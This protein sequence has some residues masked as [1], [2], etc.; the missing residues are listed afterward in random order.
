MPSRL[1]GILFCLVLA[2]VVNYGFNQWLDK[3]IPGWL[4]PVSSLDGSSLSSSL[5]YQELISGTLEASPTNAA[6]LTEILVPYYDYLAN[7]GGE[8]WLAWRDAYDKNYVDVVTQ[9]DEV[10]Q[11][12]WLSNWLT[13]VDRTAFIKYGSILAAI[14]LF[15]LLQ[16][17]FLRP[18]YWWTPVVYILALS[19]TVCLYTSF[20]ALAFPILLVG[21]FVIYGLSLRLILPIYTLELNKALRPLITLL[22]FYLFFMA[23]RGP[24]WIDYLFWTSPLYRLA[25]ISVSLLTLFFHWS[26]LDSILKRADLDLTSRITGYA[27]PLGLLSIFVGLFTTFHQSKQAGALAALNLDLLL[28][29]PEVTAGF[30]PSGPFVL[31]FA[32]VALLIIGGI[33]Y[34]I[35]RIAK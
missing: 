32:G 1:I 24:E 23:W 35:Q 34:F 14:L 18:R 27:M 15:L 13:M 29:S 2:N 19:L 12:R 26:I 33:G 7:G 4:P 16:S 3:K 5:A 22:L 30:N 31:F 9:S 21:S 20:T 25:L 8:R 28:F 11:Q 17:N 6:P 10:N